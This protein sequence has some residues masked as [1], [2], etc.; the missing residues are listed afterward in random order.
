[1]AGISEQL[2]IGNSAITEDNKGGIASAASFIRGALEVLGCDPFDPVFASGSQSE[3]LTGAL[4]GVINLVLAQRTAARDRKDF[5]ASDQIRD[6]L[7]ALGI[8]IEDT[9]QGPRWSISRSE[10][11][12]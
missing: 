2:R 11:S 10:G 5:A 8:S 1:L 9:A 12:N 7:I 6:G 3:S 4:D